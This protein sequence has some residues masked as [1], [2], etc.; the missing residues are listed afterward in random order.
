MEI[1]GQRV[2]AGPSG[3]DQVEF[4]ISTNPGEPNKPLVRVASGGEI[5]RIML[6]LKSVLAES[7]KTPTLIFDE[8]DVGVSGRIAQVVGKAMKELASFHQLICI[9]HLPQIAGLSSSHFTVIKTVADDQTTTEMRPLR[10]EERVREIAK[11]LG[12]EQITESTLQNA[13]ELMTMS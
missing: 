8:I 4:L 13:R 11:L 12:G 5:S 10:G 1:E 9:T 2:K 7:D 3:I 6:A